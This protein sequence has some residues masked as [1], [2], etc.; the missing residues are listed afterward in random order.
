MWDNCT[1]CKYRMNASD[2]RPCDACCRN[3]HDMYEATNK[4][5]SQHISIEGERE[6]DEDYKNEKRTP[7]RK[8]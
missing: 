6:G 5:K 3:K 7:Y 8:R 4:I 1:G 2:M